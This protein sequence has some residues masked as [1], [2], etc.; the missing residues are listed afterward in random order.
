MADRIDEAIQ[1]VLQ[2][3]NELQA[4]V[5]KEAGNPTG[6]EFLLNGSYGVKWLDRA[7]E[8][9]ESLKKPQIKLEVFD[10]LGDAQFKKITYCELLG[11]LEAQMKDG[12]VRMHKGVDR[13]RWF[14]VQRE[15]DIVLGYYNH[16]WDKT[17]CDLQTPD[18]PTLQALATH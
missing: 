13:S 16:I 11:I 4:A 17:P 10:I 12:S 2:L 9:L 6:G 15:G 1:A 5:L 8:R 14:Q 3:R 7:I 18:Q